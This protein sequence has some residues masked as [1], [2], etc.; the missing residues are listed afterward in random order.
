[1]HI[2]YLWDHPALIPELA[3]LH[4]AQWSYLRPGET[5]AERTARLAS[6]RGRG[7]VPS[8]VVAL[9]D[10]RLLGSAMLVGNDMS[11]RPVLSPWLAGVY[12]VDDCRGR[13]YGSALVKRIET[14][15]ALAGA[16]RLYLYTP[17]AQG[18]Y[19][20]LGWAVDERCE[21]LGHQ[22]AVMSRPLSA[23]YRTSPASTRLPS[24]KRWHE[25][26]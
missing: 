12:V 18:F 1:V 6:C 10:G 13:G 5:L 17:D 25:T 11:T 21:Y 16:N 19:E 2:E 8:V 7:G 20:R 14:E 22:V 4:H 23:V 9:E 3:R 15:A 26:K 24:S